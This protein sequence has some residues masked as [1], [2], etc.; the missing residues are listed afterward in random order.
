M[1]VQFN[2]LIQNAAITVGFSSPGILT[3]GVNQTASLEF[4][5]L[6]GDLGRSVSVRISAVNASA[7]GM[8][9]V[10]DTVNILTHVHISAGRDYIFVPFTVNLRQS[11]STT[12]SFQIV[13]DVISEAPESFVLIAE[14]LDEIPGIEGRFFTDITINDDDGVFEQN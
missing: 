11:P 10:E 6:S 5:V 14:V 1:I 9:Y 4:N 12:F 3:E 7:V 8:N 13:D 2:V